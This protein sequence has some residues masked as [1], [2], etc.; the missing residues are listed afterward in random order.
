MPLFVLNRN[1]TLRSLHGHIINFKKDEKVSVPRK[2]VPEAIALGAELVEPR[3]GDLPEGPTDPTPPVVLGGDERREK[4]FKAF[5]FVMDRG[6]RNDFTASG[7]P[8]A[9]A[10]SVICGFDVDAKERDVL[11]QEYVEKREDDKAN[12]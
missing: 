4:I 1:Y 9:K 5:K 12:A 11:W 10:L 6:Q 2:L 8:H 7:H 3:A